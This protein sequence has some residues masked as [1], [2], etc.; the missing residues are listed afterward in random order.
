MP[1]QH[2]ASCSTTLLRVTARLAVTYEAGCGQ[3]GKTQRCDGLC[4]PAA[5]RC[6]CPPW[7]AWRS[8]ACATASRLGNRISWQ[9]RR[10]LGCARTP[11]QGLWWTLE[12][13]T[14]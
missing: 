6:W 4:F 9:S 14:R 1:V 12:C 5:G 8:S 3:A 13:V 11:S 10:P 7:S 2:A